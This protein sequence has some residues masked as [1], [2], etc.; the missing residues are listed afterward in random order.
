[1]TAP[2][3]PPAPDSLPN[4]KAQKDAE[5]RVHVFVDGRVQGVWFRQTAYQQAHR[6]GVRGWVRNLPDGRVEAVYEGCR[7]AVD[8]LLA[9]TRRGPDRA[10]VTSL[11]VHDEPP[12]GEQ[13]FSI[14]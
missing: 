3:K 1:M 13:G 5:V 11:E 12:R 4:D 8:E 14:R 7:S 2:E 6:L 10:I 9:W